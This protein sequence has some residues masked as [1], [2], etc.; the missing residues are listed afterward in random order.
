MVGNHNDYA[1]P[2]QLT[3]NRCPG[4]NSWPVKRNGYDELWYNAG[5]DKLVIIAK[6]DNFVIEAITLFSYLFCAFL[7]VTFHILAA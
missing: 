1:F 6:K 5:T 3:P 2:L 7:F 4:R